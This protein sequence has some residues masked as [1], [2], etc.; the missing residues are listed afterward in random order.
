MR[1]SRFIFLLISLLVVLS[2]RGVSQAGAAGNTHFTVENY[3]KQWDSPMSSSRY[4]RKI[5][6]LV[7]EGN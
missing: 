7:E 3:Y 5:I 6:I 2:N 1:A 4:G